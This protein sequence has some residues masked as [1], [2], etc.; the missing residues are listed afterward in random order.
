MA[1]AAARQEPADG[2]V[3]EVAEQEVLHEQQPGT[4]ADE[5]GYLVSNDCADTLPLKS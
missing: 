2:E 4:E 3:G 1:A 5:C